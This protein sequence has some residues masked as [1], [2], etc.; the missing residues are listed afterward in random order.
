MHLY[1]NGKIAYIALATL[2]LPLSSPNITDL[3]HHMGYTPEIPSIL[4]IHFIQKHIIE[5]STTVEGASLIST[6]TGLFSRAIKNAFPELAVTPAE[7]L[8]IRIDVTVTF[9]VAQNLNTKMKHDYQCN[10]AMSLTKKL[11]SLHGKENAPKNPRECGQLIID[12]LPG[13]CLLPG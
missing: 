4:L 10:A 3:S 5:M 7:C 13:C 6:V 9:Q 2:Y 12:H 8:V 11:Q 1:R